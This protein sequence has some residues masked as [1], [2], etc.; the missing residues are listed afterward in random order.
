VTFLASVAALV[1]LAG[2]RKVNRPAS[3]QDLVDRGTLP[4]GLAARLMGP[5]R[6]V[7]VRGP[8]GQIARGCGMAGHAMRCGASAVDAAPQA[9]QQTR[10]IHPSQP[11]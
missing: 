3:P 2:A 10:M 4:Q 9:L 6:S 7:G 5:R 8:D 1:W 11:Q